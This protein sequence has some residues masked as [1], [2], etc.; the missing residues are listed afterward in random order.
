LMRAEFE[1]Q[2]L[3]SFPMEKID[4]EITEEEFQKVTGSLKDEVPHFARFLLDGDFPA[5]PGDFG[6]HN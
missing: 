6:K 4:E 3:T 5:P 1:Q 2:F